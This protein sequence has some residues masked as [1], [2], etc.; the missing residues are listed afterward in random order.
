[1]SATRIS[2]GAKHVVFVAAVALG[3]CGPGLGGS[4]AGVSDGGTATNGTF[5]GTVTGSHGATALTGSG[6]AAECPPDSD[7][8]FGAVCYRRVVLDVDLW[9]SDRALSADLDGDGN[10]ELLATVANPGDGPRTV[11]FT[12]SGDAVELVDVPIFGALAGSGIPVASLDIDGDGDIE[13][14]SLSP[15]WPDQMLVVDY[16]DGLPTFHPTTLPLLV[17]KVVPGEL[18]AY[19]PG[20]ALGL[21]TVDPPRM[22]GSWAC[23]GCE[24]ESVAVI[25]AD[26]MD[27]FEGLSERVI[28]PVGC[29]VGKVGIPADLDGDGRGELV[30][31]PFF[32]QLSNGIGALSRGAT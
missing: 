4:S 20:F 30:L 25:Q 28:M 26:S 23:K 7:F 21:P 18:L 29:T 6:G 13:V 5:G 31:L 11:I 22:L 8:A 17:P 15:W 9:Y 16:E 32:S 12:A 27:T 3:G 24:P 1:M 2:S 14:V 19:G 10:E